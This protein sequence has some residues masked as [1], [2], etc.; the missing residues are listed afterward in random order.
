MNESRILVSE[1]VEQEGYNRNYRYIY[2][3]NNPLIYTDPDGES[4]WL[5]VGILAAFTYLKAAH[6]NTEEEDQ[7]NPAKWA[8]NPFDWS[9]ENT[10]IIVGVQG[11]S[12]GNITA[13]TGL[14]DPSTGGGFIAG[15]NT[16]YGW[17]TGSIDGSGVTNFS[18]PSINYSAAEENTAKGISNYIQAESNFQKFKDEYWAARTSF[19]VGPLTMIGWEYEFENDHVF[20]LN[21]FEIGGD[22]ILGGSV[23][24]GWVKDEYTGKRRLIYGKNKFL[25]TTPSVGVRYNRM[26]YYYSGST[27]YSIDFFTKY[28]AYE[29]NIGGGPGV[30]GGGT[31]FH[32]YGPSSPIYGNGAY[33]D[34]GFSLFPAQIDFGYSYSY[35]RR[36]HR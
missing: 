34:I 32:R 9:G 19:I 11:D 8:W 4:F 36:R 29:T 22:L 10:T 16:N 28:D 24:I 23:G 33:F 3:L 18:Y 30:F 31:V 5:A 20:T 2:C 13:Y 17:G 15:Y 21:Y 7:S 25:S 12:D 35:L 26:N 6:D 14:T 1:K 27:D